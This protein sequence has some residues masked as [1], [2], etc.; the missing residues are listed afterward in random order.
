MS[1]PI[2]LGNPNAKSLPEV[3]AGSAPGLLA[4]LMPDPAGEAKGELLRA[5]S[6]AATSEKT[7]T[8]LEAAKLLFQNSQLSKIPGLFPTVKNAD[9]TI[10]INQEAVA[11]AVGTY[12]ASGGSPESITQIFKNANASAEAAR[13]HRFDI[14]K[15]DSKP[16]VI[17]PGSTALLRPGSPLIPKTSTPAGGGLADT[18]APGGA[19]A[20]PTAVTSPDDAFPAR[21]LN[22]LPGDALPSDPSGVE[23]GL[24]P[25]DQPASV[26]AATV[27]GEP[28]VKG[29]TV[30]VPPRAGKGAG[31]GGRF[32]PAN[33]NTAMTENMNSVKK[34]DR[35]LA[36]LEAHPDSVGFTKG[37][38]NAIPGVGGNLLNASDKEGVMTRALVGDIGSLVIHDR[39]GA[40]VTASEFP[41]LK[42][43]IPVVGDDAATIK[44]KLANFRN[45][46]MNILNDMGQVYSAD[47]GYNPNPALDKFL[48]GQAAPAAPVDGG[49][50]ASV[51]N[52]A[53]YDALPSGSTYVAPD[54][55]TRTKR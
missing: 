39:S 17:S 30:T 5:Q 15:E 54:G 37:M 12:I 19:V 47:Q 41:R 8:D 49:G 36:Q 1:T 22:A 51:S 10:G 31:P 21:D 42:P 46:Y 44:T 13:D 40:A 34:V 25:G 55:Q 23:R 24:L 28:V 26:L 18:V 35:A 2:F 38:V 4:P 20:S 14:E 33:I 48:Q 29:N 53:E 11:N 45:E 3:L 43:F 16:L 52:Q 6:A 9:G 7:K 50:A 32:I 27:A